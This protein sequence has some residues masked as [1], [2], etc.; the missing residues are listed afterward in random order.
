MTSCRSGSGMP[1]VSNVLPARHQHRGLVSNVLPAHQHREL[2]SNVLSAHQHQHRELV[3]SVL[4]ARNQHRGLVMC[5]QQDINIV[6][7]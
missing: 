2:V 6:I 7:I 4:S 1:R 3:S 5:S